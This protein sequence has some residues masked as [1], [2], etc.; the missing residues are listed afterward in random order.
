MIEF[1]SA[2]EFE[3]RLQ[4]LQQAL[5]TQQISVGRSR[6]FPVRQAGPSRRRPLRDSSPPHP[7]QRESPS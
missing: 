7:P 6:A 1:M 2:E 3:Q 4:A 5:Q